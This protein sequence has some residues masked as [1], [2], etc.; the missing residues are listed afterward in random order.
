VRLQIKRHLLAAALLVLLPVVIAAA[1]IGYRSSR[2]R[3]PGSLT[4]ADETTA[5]N[6]VVSRKELK[7]ESEDDI[8]LLRRQV[9]ALS[10]SLG[11]DSFAAAA[12][13]TAASELARNVWAHAHGGVAVVEQVARSGRRGLRLSLADDGPGIVEVDRAL[14]GGYSTAN[15]LG[16]GLSGSSRLVDEFDIQTTV[17]AGTTVTV[18]KWAR[19]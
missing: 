7:V 16:I 9:R 4:L 6:E 10:Q 3:P 19:F 14:E 5:T 12:I 15:S 11:F 1:V 8:V 18:L 2:S 13:T 17:G